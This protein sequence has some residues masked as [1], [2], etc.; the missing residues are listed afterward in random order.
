MAA[1]AQPAEHLSLDVEPASP[2]GPHRQVLGDVRDARAVADAVSGAEVVVHAAAAL[3]S[4]R[5]GEIYSTDVYGTR[6]VLEASRSA[7]VGRVVH[8]SSTA[9]YGL[10]VQVPTPEDHPKAPVDPYSTAKVEAERICAAYRDRGLCVPVLRP[11]TFLGPR[12]LGLFAMLF[13]WADEGRNFPLLGRGDIRCQMLDVSDLVHAVLAAMTLPDE[14]VNDAFN[15]DTAEFTTL[16]DDFQAVLD[17][18]GHGGR[19]VSLP[20]GPA[21][22][23]LRLLDAARLS[24]V[25]KRLIYKLRADSFV[26][27]DRARERLGFQPR[28]SNRNSLLRTYEWWRSQPR[29][30]ATRGGENTMNDFTGEIPGGDPA[31]EPRPNPEISYAA[32]IWLTAPQPCSARTE[33]VTAIVRALLEV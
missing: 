16:R 33:P 13:E 18:A 28:Y 9:V 15:V 22:A 2:F 10:P 19:V 1:G 23:V 29:G 14:R 5:P 32:W 30:Q 27:I 11:K 7:G 6:T 12:R 25:Y 26:S 17:A 24:P 21:I 8:I 20:I 31:N 3:P 4:Y